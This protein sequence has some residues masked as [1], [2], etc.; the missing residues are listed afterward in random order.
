MVSA[1]DNV[2]KTDI[3]VKIL[4]VLVFQDILKFEVNVSSSHSDVPQQKNGTDLNVSVKIVTIEI[5]M[6]NVLEYQNVGKMRSGK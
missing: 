5:G 6:V 1:T 2:L 3:L 4:V